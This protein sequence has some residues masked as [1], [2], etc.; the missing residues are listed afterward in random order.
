MNIPVKRANK[1]HLRELIPVNSDSDNGPNQSWL[2]RLSQ[3][4]SS[5]PASRED[6][7]ELLRYAHTQ[8]ILDNEALQI[9]EGA[10]NVADQQVREIMIPR[11]RMTV[12]QQGADTEQILAM[13]I[14]SNHSRFPVIGESVDDIKGILLA[15]DL[16]PL[17][18]NGYQNFSIDQVIRPATI[19]PES[20]RLNVLLRE[21][22]EQRYHMAIVLDEYASVA[23]LVTIE[24]ILEEIVGNIEDETDD[25]EPKFIRRQQDGS[26]LLAALTPIEDFNEYFGTGLSEDEFD[27]IGGIITKA[28][29]HLPK[30]GEMTTLDS[31]RF[32]VV[33]AD[34]RQVHSLEMQLIA[35]H[36]DC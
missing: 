4:F 11:S 14:E 27:T 32:H 3:T 22:R 21:F 15:K 20:K 6:I 18:L 25:D 19:I 8:K 9:M 12:V 29:G 10:L 34:A 24:D 13:I 7:A 30:I 26:Y 36:P 35:A 28:F 31:Y 1:R 16:L 17:A 2:A 5:K 23:G 33:E